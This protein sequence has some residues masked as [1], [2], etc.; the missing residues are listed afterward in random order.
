[1][2]INQ[3]LEQRPEAKRE[4]LILSLGEQLSALISASRALTA[5]AAATFQPDMQPAAFHVAQW[6]CAFGPAKASKVAEAVAMD[7]SATSRLTRELVQ[8]GIVESRPDPADGRGVLLS[9]TDRGRKRMSE[10]NAL[11]GDIFRHRLEPWSDGDLILLT[12]L[13]RQLLEVGHPSD[14]PH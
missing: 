13:L 5:T 7:R 11:K 2:A 14:R 4:Q 8:A 12:Q 3:D 6:L 1:M 9:V 10:A